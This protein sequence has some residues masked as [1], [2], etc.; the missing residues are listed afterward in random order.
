[1][2]DGGYGACDGA[3][4][5]CSSC[6]VG[7]LP[8]PDALKAGAAPASPAPAGAP[9][10]FQGPMPTP[11]GAGA[12]GYIPGPEAAPVSMP[13]PMLQ[14]TSY[15]APYMPAAGAGM[16][17]PAAR[18]PIGGASQGFTNAFTATMAR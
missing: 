9:P 4:G 6:A 5:G 16:A 8:A 18:T 12:S 11:A 2:C 1:M 14:P 15:Q 13:Y 10:T 3:I 17:N 7:Q